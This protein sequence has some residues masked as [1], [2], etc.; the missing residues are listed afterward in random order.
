MFASM[1][2]TII[3]FY[4]QVAGRSALTQIDQTVQLT[5]GDVARGTTCGEFIY[6]LRLDHAGYLLHRRAL[7]GSGQPL[8]EIAYACGFRD[9]PHFARRFRNRF[10]FSPGACRISSKRR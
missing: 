4:F 6:S 10:G 3:S 5:A 7:R 9:Y 1:A 2:L 8:S